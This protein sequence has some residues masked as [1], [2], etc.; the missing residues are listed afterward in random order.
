MLDFEIAT[1]QALREVYTGTV[2]KGCIFHWTQCIYRKIAAVGL[3]TAYMDK[4]DKYLYLRKLMSL[5]LLPAEHITSAFEILEDQAAEAGGPI[6]EVTNYMRRIW[7]DGSQWRV[8]NW[9]VFRES[10]RT[11]NDV[12]GWHR[13][14]NTRAGKADLGFYV[15]VPL[16]KKEAAIVDLQIRLVSEHQL[17]R[18]HRKKYARVH[19]RLFD[20]WDIDIMFRSVFFFLSIYIFV[21][22]TCLCS[23]RQLSTSFICYCISMAHRWNFIIW[24]LYMTWKVDNNYRAYMGFSIYALQFSPTF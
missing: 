12:E 11:N 24:F 18:F 8:E 19:G 23:F 22:H 9:S 6:Q 21:K 20:A 16:L 7:I 14:I 2:L 10:V 3:A 13:R 4:K 15:L 1:W 5:P 17:T